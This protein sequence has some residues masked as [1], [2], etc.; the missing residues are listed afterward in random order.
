VVQS[1]KLRVMTLTDRPF[2]VG[3][4]EALARTIATRLDPARFDRVLCATR[5]DP[6]NLR[7]DPAVAAAGVRVL[8]LER[9]SRAAI[10]A[11]LPLISFLRDQRVDVLHTHKFGSNLWGSLLGRLAGVPV[12][13]AHE[14]TWSFEGQPLRCFL[15]RSII[16]RAADVVVAVSREDRRKMVEVEHI[17]PNRIRVVPNGIAPKSPERGIDVRTQLGISSTAPVIGCVGN[18][19][20]QKALHHLIDCADI[21]VREFPDLRVLIV[22]GGSDEA[23]IRSL[24]RSR[25]LSK[26][27]LLLGD[28]SDVP[29][30]LAALD[31]SVSTSDWE[32]SPLAV[33]EYMAAGKPVVAT[34]VGGVPDLV[35]HGV[36]GL[37][38]EPGDVEGLAGAIAGLLRDPERRAVMGASGRRRQRLEF[39]INLMVGRLELLYE[40]LFRVTN[41][42][43]LER[44][45]PSPRE[46]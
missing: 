26:T 8:K 37:L 38:V 45:A 19:R 22:G 31:L 21:L 20:P 16:A 3:G 23:R 36:Q 4:A 35:T 44:W 18:L 46:A 41:R 43:R 32:G 33:M 1:R 29:N 30:I 25:D 2:E 15:D 17:D 13:I 7:V 39:D 42:A 24:V 11:W 28:R 6:L 34:R 5:H 40:E 14:H 12:I 9:G 27:V 10:A